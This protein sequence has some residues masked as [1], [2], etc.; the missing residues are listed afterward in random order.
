MTKPVS[1]R[2]KSK[3]STLSDGVAFASNSFKFV[4]ANKN[5]I[6]KELSKLNSDGVIKRLRKGIYYKPNQT[7][8]GEEEPTPISIAKAIAKL[9]EAH[10]I[11]DGA[12]ALNLLDLS[13]ERPMKYVYLNDKLHKRE[14]IGDIEI[15]FKRVNPKKLIGSNKKA[16][17]VLS[18]INYLG[19]SAF[20]EENLISRFAKKL[21][22][23]DIKD[24]DKASKG[25]PSWVQEKVREIISIV[26][27]T[28]DPKLYSYN[29]FW[30]T[31]ERSEQ[32]VYSII[33]N[34]LSSMNEDD[35]RILCKEFGKVIVES[36][37]EDK[38]K[39]M[40]EKGYISTNGMD[41]PLNGKFNRNEMYK[42]LLGVINDC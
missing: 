42:Q 40:Y 7:S 39:K 20:K 18:A 12:M 29:L 38:Y 34:Y 1:Q 4:N 6:E 16:G 41:I 31:N 8:L 10:L 3:I 36:V 2:V 9:N 14:R 19:K 17:L 30:Q 33:S 32:K 21:E 23:K 26:N 35:I 5:S 24:L 22:Y 15:V 25:Y 28:F 11:P 37:L 13:N 27:I